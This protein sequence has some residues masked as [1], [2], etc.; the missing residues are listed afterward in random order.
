MTKLIQKLFAL[1]VLALFIVSVLPAALAEEVTDAEETDSAEVDDTE[2]DVTTTE[3]ADSTDGTEDVATTTK[4]AKR[5]KAVRA[6]EKVNQ[7]KERVDVAKENFLKARER[8]TSAKEKFTDQKHNL[9]S[10]KDKVKVCDKETGDCTQKKLELRKGVRVH[11]EKTIALIESS[12][13]RLIEKVENSKVLTDEEKEEALVS[14]VDI[15]ETITAE[16]EKVEALAEEATAAE[17]REAIK[18]LKKAWIEG[19]KIQKSIIATLTNAKLEN[20]FEKLETEF[21]D[22]MEMRITD[23]EE[24]GVDVSE[25]EVLLAEY[26]TEVAELENSLEKAKEKRLEEDLEAW[27]E[28]NVE[29]RQNLKD[30]KEALRDFMKKYKE[31]KPT[32]LEE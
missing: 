13:E 16:K 22:G 21:V 15:E 28:A 19:R 10:L 18:N 30:A 32:T 3:E 24:Q 5:V 7:I 17:L 6:K 11:L 12:L 1:A 27:R 23:L 2:A 25:L 20:L 14:L 29:V 8:Y 4:P 26:K 9:I 31:L